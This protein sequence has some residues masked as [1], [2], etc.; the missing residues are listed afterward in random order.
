V[1]HPDVFERRHNGPRA[2]DEVEMLKVVGAKDIGTLMT[3]TVP[4]SIRNRPTMK[5]GEALTE[6]DLSSVF[7]AR[8]AGGGARVPRR[9][10]SLRRS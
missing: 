9:Q 4:A 2:A 6:D 3:E 5:V 7:D 10:T 1:Q 8:S